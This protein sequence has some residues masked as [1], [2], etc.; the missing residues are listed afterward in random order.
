MADRKCKIISLTNREIV[1]QT[2][3]YYKEH[4]VYLTGQSW[5][6]QKLTVNQNDIIS[7]HWATEA[8]V[9]VQIQSVNSMSETTGNGLYT[10]PKIQ[11]ESGAVNRFMVESPGVYYYTSGFLDD[12]FSQ[13]A[14]G[15]I[16]VEQAIDY[17]VVVTVK[18]VGFDAMVENAWKNSAD[19][20]ILRRA[21]TCVEAATDLTG[22]DP[23]IM[24]PS[25]CPN[26]C[27]NHIY[28][29]Q[30]TP[31]ATN[32]TFDSTTGTLSEGYESWVTDFN[33]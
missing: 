22:K 12:L 1:C 31:T 28:S 5:F 30:R 14:N 23:S 17:Q 32:S 24:D 6:P 21:K 8:P 16:T 19:A 9:N 10:T 4:Q 7:W 13:F 29:F 25:D 27:L 15:E 33:F 3:S 18:V 20:N 26:M 11:S 2:R